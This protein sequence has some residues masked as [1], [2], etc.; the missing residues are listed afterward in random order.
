MLSDKAPL[1]QHAGRACRSANAGLY[2]WE[3]FAAWKVSLVL[4]LD[5]TQCVRT[6]SH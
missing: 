6:S 4:E 2:V 1:P 5:L 3:R